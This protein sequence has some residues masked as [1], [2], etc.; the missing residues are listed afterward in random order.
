MIDLLY[1]VDDIV[2]DLIEGHIVLISEALPAI[3]NKKKNKNAPFNCIEDVPKQP[4]SR[5]RRK[6][7]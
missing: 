4:Q 2:I 1:E 5:D 3:M 7:N 6:K